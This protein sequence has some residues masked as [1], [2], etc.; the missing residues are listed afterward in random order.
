[1]NK[2]EHWLLV[3]L[4][5]FSLIPGIYHF[6]FTL[7]YVMAIIFGVIGFIAVLYMSISIQLNQ[8]NKTS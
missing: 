2:Y 3:I 1:M 6:E 7:P 5:G 8:K 4:V